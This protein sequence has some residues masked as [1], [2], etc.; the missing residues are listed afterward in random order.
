MLVG[1]GTMKEPITNTH[2]MENTAKGM[3]SKIEG[4]G[5]G[6][7]PSKLDGIDIID[8]K[9]GGKIPIDEFQE[10]RKVSVHNV[11]TDSITLGKYTPTIENGVENWGK[12]GPDSYI[13]IAGKESTYFDLGS[14]WESIQSKY[15]L[16]PD[17]MFE[18]FNV[19]V[20]DEAIKSGK[21]IRFSHNPDLLIY[22][23]SYLFKEWRY[24]QEKYGIDELTLKGDVWIAK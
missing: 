14:E 11:E 24:L 1:H 21:Q 12:A 20:L 6:K 17:E 13:G 2:R 16:T 3:Y 9:V 8:E 23:E 19:P 18:Y 4:S 7:N 10:I 5:G 15:N 22:K